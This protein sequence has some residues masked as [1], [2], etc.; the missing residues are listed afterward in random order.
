LFF[1]Q[2]ARNRNFKQK[3]NLA[4][5]IFP[6][7]LIC[8]AGLMVAVVL[9]ISTGEGVK[10]KT[11][12][13]NSADACSLAA[14]SC[15]AGSLNRLVGMNKTL[16]PPPLAGNMVNF[17][18]LALGPAGS[19]TYYY[20]EM[21]NYYND[22]NALEM[23]ALYK[24]LYEEAGRY[25]TGYPAGGANGSPTNCASYY[26]QQAIDLATSASTAYSTGITDCQVWNANTAGDS[27]NSQ[28]AAK[29]L[30][31]A[32][33]IGA[34]KVLAEYMQKVTDFFK[35]YQTE[36]FCQ[37]SAFMDQ[38]YEGAIKTGQYYAFSN[39]GTSRLLTDSQGDDF[40]L[41]LGSGN[42]FNS[43]SSSSTFTWGPPGHECNVSA[44]VDLSKISSYDIKH[45][46]WNYPRKHTVSAVAFPC[47]GLQ[48]PATPFPGDDILNAFNVPASQNLRE[49][50]YNSSSVYNVYYYLTVALPA[51]SLAIHN[52]TQD[53]VD[54]CNADHHVCDENP[55]YCS[56]APLI[57][58][59]VPSFHC[60]TNE[61]DGYHDN[62]PNAVGNY[63]DPA[64]AVQTALI[65]NETC[66]INGLKLIKDNLYGGMVTIPMLQ[67]W[68][69][70]I[71]SNVWNTDP[72]SAPK[73]TVN[74]CQGAKDYND[75][76]TGWP[77][78]MIINIDSVRLPSWVAKC[79]VTTSCGGAATS[80]STSKF[81]GDKGELGENIGKFNN[82]YYPEI[83]GN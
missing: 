22:F 19:S 43:G 55:D 41:F 77:G 57:C 50:L 8:L 13:S 4:G 82:D 60:E 29:V 12:A 51:L 62:C 66:I 70:Q 58:C 25:L 74:N 30:E 37:A 71:Y 56:T 16:K 78:M 67:N 46:P 32:K 2:Y 11:Y 59:Y 42:F 38:A 3:N 79:T 15:M 47:T 35:K 80:T 83:V 40:N 76:V 64:R 26:I 63:F 18:G 34:F 10:A 24:L 54:C 61:C 72:A 1:F 69:Y 45:A 5:Q 14:A 75:G 68:N 7:L 49:N 65:N 23:R 44:N 53:G 9:T 6:V 36:N 20:K 52:K 28:A 33:C 31:A 81:Y 73:A 17:M 48:I 27:F 39:S 21:Y